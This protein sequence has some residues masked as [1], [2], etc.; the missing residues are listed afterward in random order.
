LPMAQMVGDSEI[1]AQSLESKPISTTEVR[2]L[3]DG[4]WRRAMMDWIPQGIPRPLFSL[5]ERDQRWSQAR[6]AISLLR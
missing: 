5:V 6:E 3:G 4:V 1:H 2:T